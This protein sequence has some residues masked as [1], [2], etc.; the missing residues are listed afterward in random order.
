MLIP[1]YKKIEYI[2]CFEF[3]VNNLLSTEGDNKTTL[4]SHV[5]IQIYIPLYKVY[6]FRDSVYMC[7]S[8][9]VLKDSNKLRSIA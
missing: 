3:P 9:V 4:F 6:T 8:H 7:V 1:S 5:T 2:L